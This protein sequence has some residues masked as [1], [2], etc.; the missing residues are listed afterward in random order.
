MPWVGSNINT[1]LEGTTMSFSLHTAKIFL[2]YPQCPLSREHM[3]IWISCLVTPHPLV[4]WLVAREL[5]ED[6]QYHLHILLEYQTKLNLRDEAFF[7]VLVDESGNS[8][9]YHPNIQSCR[10]HVKC[11]DYCRKEDQ[12]PIDNWPYGGFVNPWEMALSCLNKEDFL[13]AIKIAAPKDYILHYE[14][15]LI[16]ADFHYTEAVPEYATPVDCAPI[17]CPTIVSDWTENVKN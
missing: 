11:G 8:C 3:L 12:E 4:N 15:L 10:S 17:V 7:D 13:A 1:N 2:T 14:R 9:N 6:G 16:F 5:H